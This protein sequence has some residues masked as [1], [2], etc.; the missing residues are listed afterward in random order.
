MSEEELE[1]RKEMQHSVAT[2]GITC[3]MQSNGFTLKLYLFH[4][5][6]NISYFYFI[7]FYLLF[8]F[9]FRNSDTIFE[10]LFIMTNN[11]MLNLYFL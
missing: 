2:V 5:D 8:L 3:L 7:Y 6:H 1:C 10:N 11:I 9:I 4:L